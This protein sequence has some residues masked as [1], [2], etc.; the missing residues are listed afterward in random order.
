MA[1][2][3]RTSGDLRFNHDDD[4]MLQ[5]PSITCFDTAINFESFHSNVPVH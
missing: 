1:I 4:G 3:K 2:I 5:K